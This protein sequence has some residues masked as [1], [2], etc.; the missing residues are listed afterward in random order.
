[1]SVETFIRDRFIGKELILFFGETTETI[2]YN[3][4]WAASRELIRG[5][6]EDVKDGVI[7]INIPNNG[8][9]YINCESIV[10]FWEPGL[11]YNKAIITSLTRRT[12]K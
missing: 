6:I 11:E 2:V 12:P 3:Q 5:H 9:M 8:I 4:N 1:M 7:I 10:S